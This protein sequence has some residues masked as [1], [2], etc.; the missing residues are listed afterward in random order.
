MLT[1][2]CRSGFEAL[3]ALVSWCPLPTPL[4]HPVRLSFRRVI[5]SAVFVVLCQWVGATTVRAGLCGDDVAGSDVPCACGDTLVSSVVLGDDPIVQ[6]TC[7]S[8]G[9]LV[10]APERTAPIIID[11]NGA[12][13]RGG[14]EGVAIRVAQPGTGG[15]TIVSRRAMGQILGF[16]DAIVADQPDTLRQAENLW[17]QGCAQ[18]GVRVA[19]S[20]TRLRLIEVRSCARDGFVVRGN[21]WDLHDLRAAECGRAGFSFSGFNGRLGNT[22]AGLMAES[23]RGAGFVLMGSGHELVDCYAAGNQGDGIHLNGVRLE[24]FGCLSTN[25]GGY[26]VGGAAGASYFARNV[27]VDNGKGDAALHGHAGV[28]EGA[29]NLVGPSA[30][31][32]RRAAESVP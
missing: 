7:A 14:N 17:I 31:S 9:L 24:V 26:G 12:A 1:E 5:T 2:V 27:F 8:D 6:G 21:D 16:R 19:G 13:L 23:N 29:A 25:N 3:V 28:V 18:D 32:A 10:H 22:G 4:F 15:V 30:R 20:G 11:L